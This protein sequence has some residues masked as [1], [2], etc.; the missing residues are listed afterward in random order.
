MK[1]TQGPWYTTASGRN[2]SWTIL[3]PDGECIA[4][5]GAWQPD[6]HE[7]MIANARLIAEAGT[8]A[9]E[10]GRTPRQLAEDVILWRSIA[11]E[12]TPGGS[13]YTNP[14]RTRQHIRNLRSSEVEARKAAVRARQLAEDRAWAASIIDALI[15]GDEQARE[16]HVLEGVAFLARMKEKPDG[17]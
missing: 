11:M 14:E 13:E 7:E 9:H 1:H 12:A 8:V 17:L 10:T 2:R 15:H 16:D 5:T 6:Y 3:G 4:E